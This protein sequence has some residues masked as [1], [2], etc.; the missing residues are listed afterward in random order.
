MSSPSPLSAG[1]RRRFFLCLT[2]VF[3]LAQPGSGAPRTDAQVKAVWLAKFMHYVQWPEK[4]FPRTDQPMII[5]FLADDPVAKE[6]AGVVSDGNYTVK[7]RSLT[8]K[9]SSRPGDLASC[10][11]VFISKTAHTNAATVLASFQ[12]T[13]VLTVSDMDLF[14]SGGGMIG[15]RS[16]GDRVTFEINRVAAR[17][18]GLRIGADLMAIAQKPK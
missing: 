2:V 4:S 18:E 15:F 17:K 8:I 7:G 16:E 3:G 13:G 1:I 11:A 14:V 9:R 5:G 6:F 12:G 10:Q